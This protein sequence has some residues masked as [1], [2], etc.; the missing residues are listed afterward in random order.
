MP[1]QIG[2]IAYYNKQEIHAALFKATAETLITIAAGP[3]HL[4]PASI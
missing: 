2:D 3:K 1:A 4:C